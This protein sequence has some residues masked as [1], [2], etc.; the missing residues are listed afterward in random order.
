LN[1]ILFWNPE[2]VR[3]VRDDNGALRQEIVACYTLAEGLV[4]DSNCL[5]RLRDGASV[6]TIRWDRTQVCH[7]TPMRASQQTTA[8]APN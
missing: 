5:L 8:V 3:H 2:G 6:R 1:A 7:S 4:S